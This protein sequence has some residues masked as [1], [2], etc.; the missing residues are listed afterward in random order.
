MTELYFN[1][2]VT[3]KRNSWSEGQ[4]FLRSPNNTKIPNLS[5]KQPMCRK[6]HVGA[7]T[8]QQSAGMD[9]LHLSA[10][11][12]SESPRRWGRHMVGGAGSHRGLTEGQGS[13]EC[14][15]HLRIQMEGERGGRLNV[16]HSLLSASGPT[17]V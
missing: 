5:N 8:P 10:L 3:E 6:S 1:L 16:G 2:K 14:G 7:N 11:Q 13:P 17:V 12:G 15:E 4:R 9:A